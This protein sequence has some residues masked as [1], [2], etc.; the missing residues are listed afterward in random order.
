[1]VPAGILAA[2]TKRID[3]SFTGNSLR[4]QIAPL[5]G[6]DFRLTDSNGIARKARLIA[7]ED[8]PCCAGLEQFSIV[9]EGADLTEGLH[10]VYHCQTGSSLIS[11]MPSGEPGAG[12]IR[13]RAHFANFVQ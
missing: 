2:T 12:A 10:E 6:S 13:Q 4:D 9:F 8:G 1:M 3:N 11:L 7:V 5:I